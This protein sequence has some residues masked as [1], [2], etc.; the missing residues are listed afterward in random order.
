MDD[1]ITA[2]TAIREA[3][4]IIEANG[5]EVVG[6]VVALDRQERL[7][8]GGKES[9]IMAVR[10]ELKVPVVPILTLADLIVEV[11]GREKKRM[12]EYQER[13]GVSEE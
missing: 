13:W 11:D 4:G 5:G 2:G 1:V 12:V 3:V 10:R 8:D 6:I 9:A 7:M